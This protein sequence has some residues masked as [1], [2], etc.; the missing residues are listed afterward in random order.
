MSQHQSHPPPPPPNERLPP[1]TLPQPP[2]C[3]C[4]SSDITALNIPV[5]SLTV[6]ITASQADDVRVAQ[7]ASSPKPRV[8]A[9][10]PGR[11]HHR[12]PRSSTARS[13][14]GE[15]KKRLLGFSA[16]KNRRLVEKWTEL[17]SGVVARR[18]ETHLC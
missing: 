14:G 9:V 6:L 16:E 11:H 7:P 10:V 18:K 4:A 12:C 2:F 3:V 5:A 13:P 17:K 1:R 15:Q 8:R